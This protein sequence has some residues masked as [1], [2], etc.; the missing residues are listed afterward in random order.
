M[1]NYIHTALII[2]EM[3]KYFGVYFLFAQF[4]AITSTQSEVVFRNEKYFEK[5]PVLIFEDDFNT[6]NF[7]KWQ[8]EITMNGGGNLEFE[9]Y[10]NNRCTLLLFCWHLAVAFF[11][12]ICLLIEQ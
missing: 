1:E 7:S 12:E 2:A 10:I 3:K 9:Y 5:E 8:H 4:L 11:P 6:L